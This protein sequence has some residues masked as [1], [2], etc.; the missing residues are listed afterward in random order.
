MRLSKL[1]LDVLLDLLAY[2]IFSSHKSHTPWKKNVFIDLFTQKGQSTLI[3]I[4]IGTYV[5]MPEME[6]QSLSSKG[7]WQVT[8]NA[9][10]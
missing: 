2:L 1:L 9:A 3:N 10:Y 8:R 5:G 7:L 6:N 4:S